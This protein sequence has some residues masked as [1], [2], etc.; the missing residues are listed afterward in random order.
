MTSI[1]LAAAP[2]AILQK[3]KNENKVITEAGYKAAEVAP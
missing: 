2:Q 3:A 1:K